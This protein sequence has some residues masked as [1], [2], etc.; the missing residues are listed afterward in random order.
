LRHTFDGTTRVNHGCQLGSE[1]AEN[2]ERHA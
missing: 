2:P 1:F